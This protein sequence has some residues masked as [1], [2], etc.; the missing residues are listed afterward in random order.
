MEE[1]VTAIVKNER[2]VQPAAAVVPPRSAPARQPLIPLV[3]AV[4]AGIAFDRYFSLP[5]LT[6]LS[7]SAAGAVIFGF[8]WSLAAICLL[9]WWRAATRG[10]RYA[11][12]PLL[13]AAALTGAA[14]HHLQW[15]L[16]GVHEAARYVGLQL[17]P[18]CV[19]AVALGSPQRV[20]APSP[21]PLRAIPGTERSR[22]QLRVVQIRDAT[23]WHPASGSCRLTVEGHL[24]GVRAGDRLR[25]YGQMSRISPPLNPGEFDFAAHARA[26]R[27]LTRIRSSVPESVVII[28]PAEAGTLRRGLDGVRL[29][30]RQLVRRLVGPQQA[31]LAL[32]ILLG[33][34]DGLTAEDT[35]PYLLTGT[36]HV[37]VVSGMNVAIIATG[38]Y[39]FM[40][41]G[42]LPRR[43]GLAIVMVL[44][45]A[46]TLL[47]ETEPPV[48]RAAVFAVLIC[49]AAWTGRRGVAF[50]SLA[51]AALFVLACNPADLFRAGSQ[52]SFLAVAALIWIENWSSARREQPPDPLDKLLAESRPWPQRALMRLGRGTCRVWAASLAVWLITLPLLLSQFHIASPVSVLIAP[53]V[54]VIVGVAMWSGFVMLLIGWLIPLFGSLSGA[55][56]AMSLSALQYVVEWAETIPS[57]HFWLTGPSSWWVLVFYLALLT[58]MV[59]SR[60]RVPLRRQLA[61][62]GLWIVV[63]LLP[64]TLRMMQRD[65]LECS[66][67]A[68]GHGACVVIETPTGETIVYDAGSLG[69]PEYATQSI[70]SYLWHRGIM[71]IDGIVI[72]H[73]DVD[74]YNAVPGLL[75]RFNV[76]AIYVSPMMFDGF[77]DTETTGPD[78]LH[79]AIVAAAVPIREVW[80]GDRLEV[81]S[82]VSLE[83]IHPPRAGVVGSDNANSIV[84]AIEH[85]GSRVLLPG[86]LETPGIE[87]VMAERPYDCDVLLAPHH[88]SRRSDPPGFAAWSTPEWVVISGGDEDDIQPVVQ[89]YQAAGARVL[90]TGEDGLVRFSSNGRAVEMARSAGW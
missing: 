34:R 18:V 62:L 20:P 44:V 32:A 83:V 8:F 85:R 28:A 86:D 13:A 14:W 19:E 90:V 56:C 55:L 25:V 6:D 48:V 38:L 43:T 81:G 53:V 10:A 31:D 33:A 72:S 1:P 35:E 4:A 59:G 74:H 82:E 37:L 79:Q 41:A 63:G 71:R 2:A 27:E 68:V 84:L 47:A 9:G 36:I 69:S 65:A 30:A 42:W 66:F 49:L 22:L 87:D 16:Y 52:L 45:V 75:E 57:G 89:T 21:T 78:A 60:V 67:V 24:L 58:L 50:N 76:G 70:A 73:A 5:W 11:V 39:L 3:V 15:S 29:R 26:D 40:R 80:S 54:M 12:W 23:Q 61:A 51:F 88:G 17:Q 64:P 46:Y 7:A 77:N